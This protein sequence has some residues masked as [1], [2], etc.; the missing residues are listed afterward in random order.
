MD[1]PPSGTPTECAPIVSAAS[2][3]P[4]ACGVSLG[5]VIRNPRAAPARAIS[6]PP[7]TARAVARSVIRVRT[8]RTAITRVATHRTTMVIPIA[9]HSA[10]SRAVAVL[11]W[12]RFPRT[13][14]TVMITISISPV[15]TTTC[16]AHRPI[17]RPRVRSVSIQASVRQY[18]TKDTLNLNGFGQIGAPTRTRSSTTR[19]TAETTARAAIAAE[20]TTNGRCQERHD[21]MD[22][23]G[24]PLW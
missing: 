14:C 23:M 22:G 24:D 13:T 15:S 6:S 20:K 4:A 18:A 10:E 16:P 17:R 2:R 7:R 19:P 9:F 3:S 8:S 12:L 21:G 11:K 5:S 1:G